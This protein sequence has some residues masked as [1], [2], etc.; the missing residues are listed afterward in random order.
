MEVTQAL[1]DKAKAQG[2]YMRT[3]TL[4]ELEYR[5]ENERFWH[6]GAGCWVCF[7]RQATPTQSAC[8]F[9]RKDATN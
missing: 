6:P 2:F 9:T 1:V 4:Y 3:I 7:M 5:R 8:Y